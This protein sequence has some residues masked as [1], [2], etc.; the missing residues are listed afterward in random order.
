MS[1]RHLED[2]SWS[3]L[4]DMSWRRLEDMFWRRLQ[5]VFSVTIFCLLRRFQD[6]FKTSSKTCSRRICKTSSR[7]LQGVFR[8]SWKTKNCHA[9]DVLKT[10]S[11]LVLKTS[12]RRLQDV[13]K[14]NKCLL[15]TLFVS[16]SAFPSRKVETLQHFLW[17]LQDFPSVCF[18]TGRFFL[19]NKSLRIFH[20]LNPKI[21]TS[22]RTLRCCA[23]GVIRNLTFD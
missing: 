5:D 16:K 12:S 17:Q 14:T 13:F 7:R 19:T 10:S 2:M 11:R 6:V 3:Y 8:T 4:E 21:S 15:G 18:S 20:L 1:W 9:E 22:G 23:S